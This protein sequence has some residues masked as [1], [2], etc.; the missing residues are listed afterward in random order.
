MASLILRI[1]N[2]NQETITAI[3]DLLSDSGIDYSMTLPPPT[4]A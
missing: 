4:E 1:R 2:I 3:T